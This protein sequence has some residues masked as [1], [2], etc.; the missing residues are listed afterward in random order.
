MER[1]GDDVAAYLETVAPAVRR[2]DAETLVAMLREITGL[3]PEL[4]T[5]RIIGFGEYHY[6]YASGHEG[7]S[8]AIGFA[9]RRPA[10]TVYLPDGVGSHPDALSRLGPH[11]TGT[12]CLYIKNLDAVDLEVLRE[13]MTASYRTVTA[14]TYGKRAHEGG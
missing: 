12:G 14:G 13:I 9:A 10:T 6:K 2:R 7:T 3:E 1:T 4:W 11:T 8:S 5:G